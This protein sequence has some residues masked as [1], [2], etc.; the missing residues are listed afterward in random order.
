M[1]RVNQ[2]SEQYA[3]PRGQGQP[4]I[5]LDSSRYSSVDTLSVA[6]VGTWYV[7]RNDMAF[8]PAVTAPTAP[9]TNSAGY[10]NPDTFQIISAGLDGEFFTDDDLSNM[11]PSTWGDYKKRVAAGVQ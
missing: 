10:F 8:N 7:W 6:G 4:Y 2:A 3:P 5:Y 1:L 9:L 11:W